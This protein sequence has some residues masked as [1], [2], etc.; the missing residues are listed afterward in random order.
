MRV[1]F[2]SSFTRERMRRSEHFSAEEMSQKKRKRQEKDAT[3]MI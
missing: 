1:L 2:S 3:A